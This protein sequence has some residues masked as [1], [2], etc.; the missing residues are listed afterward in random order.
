MISKLAISLLFLAAPLFAQSESHWKFF[1]SSSYSRS[2]Y[3]T[4]DTTTGRVFVLV[5]A[6]PNPVWRVVPGTESLA[7]GNFWLVFEA[8][9]PLPSGAVILF[10]HN[11]GRVWQYAIPAGTKDYKSVIGKFVPMTMD[12]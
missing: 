3:F 2:S 4:L 6:T 11:S 8:E 9:A 7:G 5:A 12:E 10:D 1:Y